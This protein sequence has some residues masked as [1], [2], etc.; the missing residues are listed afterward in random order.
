MARSAGAGERGVV[1]AGGSGR[2]RSRPCRRCGAARMRLELAGRR[3]QRASRS[4]ARS[5][6]GSEAG[7][8]RAAPAAAPSTRAGPDPSPGDAAT[9]RSSSPGRRRPG[10]RRAGGGRAAAAGAGRG[11]APSSASS[12]MA[13]TSSIARARLG[14]ARLDQH[15]VAV[16]RAERREAG[17]AARV[18][19]SR[20]GREVAD[21]HLGVAVGRGAHHR[22]GRARVQAVG[23]AHD[24]LDAAPARRRRRP[25][26]APPGASA[27]APD[28][29]WAALPASPA[30]ASRATSS[31]EPP[32]R[33]AAAA[34]TAP[35]TSGRLA[36]QHA[37]RTSSSSRSSAVS[38]LSTAEPRS[39]STSTGAPPSPAA[40]MAPITRTAS[41]P[42]GS[43]GSSSP[44]ARLDADV[45]AAH[46]AR[47]LHHARRPGARCATR[48]PGRR[49][50]APGSAQAVGPVEDLHR[51]HRGAVG[52][53]RRSA[54][55]R[56]PSRRPTA[57]RRTRRT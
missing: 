5:P 32:A 50:P 33:A 46:L 31:S 27:A 6:G 21:A 51:V 35:S 56:S 26:R 29:R 48:R 18:G 39:I 10:A 43:P 3:G 23:G 2:R 12:T 34:A 44:P 9:P 57:R 4:A 28:P 25:R 1:A 36:Q 55:G 17:E 19:R 15:A 52:G 38:A 13:R 42:I 45:L 24:G 30:R 49:G 54:S 14:P 37:P 47:Q 20:P 40:S 8:L 22:G 16:E 53:R 7:A 11:R 41:V